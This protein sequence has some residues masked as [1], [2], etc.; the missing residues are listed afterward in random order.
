[1]GAQVARMVDV[2]YMGQATVIHAPDT[3]RQSIQSTLHDR[4][5]CANRLAR[6]AHGVI[7]YDALDIQGKRDQR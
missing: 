2:N 4:R 6:L 7:R 1:V 5:P 3:L